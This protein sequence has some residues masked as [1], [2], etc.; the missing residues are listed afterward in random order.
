MDLLN[1]HLLSV[2]VFGPLF[3]AIAGLLIP[4]ASE[5]GRTT[6]RVWALMGSV[7]T[8]A[9]L[10]L[11]VVVLIHP[12]HITDFSPFLLARL[13]LVV[14]GVFFFL[15]LRTGR[16]ITRRE[17]VFLLGVYILFLMSEIFLR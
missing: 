16:K 1:H 4:V 13:F 11:G 2:I 3:W 14:A 8:C 6:L 17:G 15:F 5:G 9:T 10:V 12:I 7:I